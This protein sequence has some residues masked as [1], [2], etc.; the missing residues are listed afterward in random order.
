MTK[1]L[2]SGI[3]KDYSTGSMKSCVKWGIFVVLGDEII[4]KICYNYKIIGLDIMLDCGE[5]E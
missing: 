5:N 3:A 1:N 2:K 4:S